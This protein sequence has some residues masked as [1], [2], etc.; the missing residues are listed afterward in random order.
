M[1]SGVT[2]RYDSPM[3]EARLEQQFIDSADCKYQLAPMLVSPLASAV[4]AVLACITAGGRVWSVGA[5]PTAALAT[6]VSHLLLAGFERDRPG[7]AAQALN[8]SECEDGLSLLRRLQVLASAEDVLLVISVASH[9]ATLAPLIDAAQ[10]M[11]MTVVA[12]VGGDGGEVL[13]HLLDTDVVVS[14]EHAR[15]SRVLELQYM[16]LHA[17]C[18]GLDVQLL[19]E[20]IKE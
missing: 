14:I 7:L 13:N 6:Y 9:E 5:G 19:G 17:M 20:E 2:Q 18:D 11:G 10:D 8:P 16:A 3:L 1:N 12:L 4:E 15:V